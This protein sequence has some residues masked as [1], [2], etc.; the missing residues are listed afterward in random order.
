MLPAP[1]CCELGDEPWK[2]VGKLEAAPRAQLHATL[3][4]EREHP[5]AVELRFP[6]PV[7][8]IERRSPDSASIGANVA[9]IAAACRKARA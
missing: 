1:C 9:G 5:I 6:H 8:A 7:R 3:V 4:D 2:F